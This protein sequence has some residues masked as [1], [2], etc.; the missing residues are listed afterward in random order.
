MAMNTIFRLRSLGSFICSLCIWLFLLPIVARGEDWRQFRGKDAAGVYSG[1]VPKQWGDKQNLKWVVPLPGKGVSSP[2]IIGDRVFVTAF[3]GFGQDLKSPGNI[4]DLRRHLVC[5]D[6]QT[7]AVLWHRSPP[8]RFPEDKFEGFITDHGYASCTP[9]SD[10]ERVF[11]FFGK[12]GVYAFDVD[13]KPLWQKFVGSESG[14]TEWGTGASPSIH[15]SLLLVNACDETQALLAFDRISGEEVWRVEAQL[16]EG[17]YSTPVVGQ[18]ADGSEEI[19][20]PLSDEIWGINPATGK[21]KWWVAES[22]GKYICTTPVIGDGVAYVA[23][24]SKVIAIRLGGV[25]DVTQSHT[26]W[27]RNAGPGVPSPVLEE[28]KL[29]WVGTNGILTC[30]DAG[31]GK[32]VWRKRMGKGNRNIT[33]AS[34]TK[35]NNVWLSMTQLAGTIAFRIEPEFEELSVNQFTG[36]KTPFKCSFAAANGE[37]F[38]RSDQY[39]YCIAENGNAD[40]ADVES[41]LPKQRVTDAFSSM[42]QGA[43]MFQGR[44]GNSVGPAQLLMTF[45]VNNDDKISPEELAESPMPKFVQSIMMA[46]GDKNKDGYIDAE[47]R[48]KMQESMQGKPGEII[49][50]KNAANRPVRPAVVAEAVLER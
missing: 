48:E 38:V 3:S 9:V 24:S 7:G 31:T 30:A 18:A 49:G 37:L 47:E 34:L 13:G 28:G 16:Y 15:K 35:A 22:L 20:I 1:D 32:T 2:V 17:S 46:K 44:S 41:Q 29:Y 14:P 11:A 26:L 42:I 4:E 39:L 8:T 50:R 21:L 25:G 43:Q 6:R 33:Y 5:L 19:V 23:A 27:S 40:L 12:S 45:D 36:D 10:G